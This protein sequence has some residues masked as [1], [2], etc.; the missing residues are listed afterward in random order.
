MKSSVVH[1]ALRTGSS[2]GVL[3]FLSFIAGCGGSDSDT[4]N[5]SQ[6][7]I[8]TSTTLSE[9]AACES[10]SKLAISDTTF[11]TVKNQPAGDFT[12]PQ[13]AVLSGLPGFCRIAATAK[14]SAASNIRIEIWMPSKNW[15]GKYLGLGNGGLGGS[16]DYKALSLGL[17]RGYAVAHT[18]MG[19]SPNAD[20]LI[21]QPE[22]WI[23]YGHRSTHLMT[24]MAKEVIQSYYG[25]N[26]SYSYFYGCSTGGGQ[27]LHEAQRYPADYN[28][29]VAGAPGHNRTGTHTDIFWNFV[30]TRGSAYLPQSKLNLLKKTATAACD[31]AD[32]VTDGIIN[33]PEKCNFNPQ[34]LQCSGADSDSCLTADQVK[35]AQ[36]IYAGP[37]DT[38]TGKQIFPGPAP[39][40]ETG[41]GLGVTAP[42]ANERAPFD[43]IFKTV[44]G[45]AWDWKTFDFSQDMTTMD[46]ALGPMVNALNPDL[47]SFNSLGGKIISFVGLTDPILS[48]KEPQRY[49]ERVEQTM[50]GQSAKF[51]RLYFAPG[52]NHCSGGDGPNVFGNDLSQSPWPTDPKRDLLAALETWVEKGSAP[53]SLI[54]TKFVGD[55]T[56][57]A[58]LMSRPL[59]AWPKV[60]KYKG[61][62]D[63][64]SEDSF[65]CS[66][67]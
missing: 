56:K 11:T 12:P 37:V 9:V 39:G 20:T 64:N 58:V 65:I 47:N 7:E 17:A 26:A 36:S 22:R 35:A 25:K 44:F 45:P 16:I 29:I 61:A 40:S 52:M 49:F 53:D 14:P 46:T 19:T 67:P 63:P 2:V 42:A 62:G 10:V 59:C 66:N 1:S 32:S 41:W 34:V 21:G 51:A 30:V 31:G 5:T 18:D 23:D 4:T 43:A 54:A 13:G 6:A 15:N 55:N 60:I 38:V 27:G 3:A 48:Y 50:P 33:A 8:N 57:N 24:T 28:G